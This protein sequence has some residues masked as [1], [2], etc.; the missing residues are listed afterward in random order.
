MRD[1]NARQY[2]ITESFEPEFF[3]IAEPFLC[4]GGTFFDVGANF[5][6]C[7]FGLMASLKEKRVDYHLFEAN[8]HLC[9]LLA[10]SAS[11][12]QNNSVHI[13]CCCVSD[14]PG[15]STLNIID[16]QLGQSFI[17]QNGVERVVN[18]T[19]DDYIKSR[20]I[21][22]VNLIKM[23]IEGHEP[24]ALKG[25]ASSLRNGL[26]DA[27]YLEVSTV[28]LARGNYYPKDCFDL[29]QNFGFKLYYCKPVDFQTK[30]LI[31][32][33]YIVQIN[34]QNLPVADLEAFPSSY[35]TDILAVRSN[36]RY[37]K[38]RN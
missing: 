5:G 35:Q 36:L 38:E 30:D 4:Q 9:E 8:Q 22:S 28:N 33:P 29:L 31:L 21:K 26:I 32:A 23:D 25:A 20:N 12:H 2:L 11:L 6:L 37:F 24:L 18:L 15:V 10:R 1:A 14:C 27:I 34:D 7:S 13:N 3:S 19:I 17:S 16:G